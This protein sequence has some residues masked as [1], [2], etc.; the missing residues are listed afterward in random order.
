M[1][2]YKVNLKDLIQLFNKLRENRKY[3]TI[4]KVL[5]T[6]FLLLVL[7]IKVNPQN[8][9]L[10]LISTNFFL[11]AVSIFLTPLLYLI[12]SLKWNI[13]LKHVGVKQSLP[14]VMKV[15]LIGTFYGM[16][17]PGRLGELMRSYYIGNKKSKT[18]PTVILEK[19]IDIFTLIILSIFAILVFFSNLTALYIVL[20][21]AVSLILVVAIITNRK[22]VGSF[23]K[24]LNI[25]A[26]SYENYLDVMKYI[27]RDKRCMSKIFALTL[28]YYAV[29]FV[30]AAFI[31]KA[32]NPSVNMLLVFSLPIIILLGNVP[33][34]ISGL[35]LRE[36]VTVIC[37]NALGEKVS[38]G[39]SFSIIMFA[40]IV[41]IPGLVGFIFTLKYGSMKKEYKGQLS[42]IFSPF[43]EEWRMKRVGKWLKG[44]KI[45]DI[46]CGTGGL[47]TLIPKEVKYTGIDIDKESIEKAKKRRK[48]NVKFYSLDISKNKF[49]FK[50]KFDSIVLCAIIEHLDNPDQML[51]NLRHYLSNDGRIIITTPTEKAEKI[52]RM[53]S[54]LRLFSSEAFSEHKQHFPKENLIKLMNKCNLEIVHYESFELGFNHLIILKKDSGCWK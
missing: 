23:A 39:F 6:L 14:L 20:T 21:I 8:I 27:G 25:S 41:F 52:L 3:K 49:P 33:I 48:N 7:L 32:L 17:T 24:I 54:K 4:F 2:H 46:G 42:G 30:L 50:N 53:G 37:F 9:F 43:L 44:K 1:F 28:C 11:L 15:V 10:I 51:I 22:T 47:L 36:F 31:L 35:G 40:I 45:L 26:E 34:T 38:I 29:S 18:I 13:L 12:R 19:L 16:I 5:L